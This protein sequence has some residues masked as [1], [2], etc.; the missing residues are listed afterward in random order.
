MPNNNKNT[1]NGNNNNTMNMKH[2]NNTIQVLSNNNITSV[3]YQ[4]QHDDYLAIIRT[5]MNI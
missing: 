5:Q 4:Q 2:Q 1:M 3:D